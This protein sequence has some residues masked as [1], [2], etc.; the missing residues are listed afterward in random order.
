[1]ADYEDKAQSG[2]YG[3]ILLKNNEKIALSRRKSEAFLKFIH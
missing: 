2:C 1:M 3:K